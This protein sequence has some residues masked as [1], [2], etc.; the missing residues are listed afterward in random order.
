MKTE[1]ILLKTASI[2]IIINALY[3]IYTNN[4]IDKEVLNCEAV[5]EHSVERATITLLEEK[6]KDLSKN[7]EKCKDKKDVDC[8]YRK[9]L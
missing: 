4:K 2:L 8:V 6:V 1:L 5:C 9:G 7:L 3:S